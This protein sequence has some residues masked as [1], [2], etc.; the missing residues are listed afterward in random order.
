MTKKDTFLE[1]TRRREEKVNKA[2][3]EIAMNNSTAICHRGDLEKRNND[4]EDFLEVSVW[5]LKKMLKEAYELGQ[6][7]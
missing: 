7:N 5:G 2:I 6:Q 4:N 1:A 3:L